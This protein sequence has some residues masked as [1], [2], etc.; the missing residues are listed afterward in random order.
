MS[1]A[2]PAAGEAGASLEPPGP[3]PLAPGSNDASP[4]E[5][6]VEDLCLV[7]ERAVE[8]LTEGL[9]S[10]Y[11]PDL[12]QSKQALQELTQ[13]QAVLL[14]TLEQEISKFKECNS[15]LDINT[16]FLEAKHYHSKLVN[17]R[18]EMLMLHEKTSKLKKRALKLQQKRQKEELEREQQR[19]REFEREKQLTAKPAKRT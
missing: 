13:N 11:L 3:R 7:D 8:Q 6:L 15:I 1:G 17:I 2:E 9:I 19:E 5:G 12:Q 18:K 4:D 16:L 14:D 10:H